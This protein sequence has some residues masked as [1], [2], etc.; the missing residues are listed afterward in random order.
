MTAKHLRVPCHDENQVNNK[1]SILKMVQNCKQYSWKNMH[2]F[3]PHNLNTTYLTPLIVVIFLS[4][5]ANFSAV[6]ES[7]TINDQWFPE[8]SYCKEMGNKIS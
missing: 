2:L 4:I 6:S 5:M 1:L 3:D 8:T 7:S